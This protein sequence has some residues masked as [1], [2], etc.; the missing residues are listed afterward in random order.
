[1]QTQSKIKVWDP[2]V[3]VFHWTLVGTFLITF[4]TEDDFMSLHVWAGYTVFFAVLIRLVWGLI[5]TQH[6]RFSDFVTSP[7]VAFQYLRDTLLLRAKR[8]I[9][10]NPAGG[11]MIV[12]M[13]ISLL[14]TTITGI[15]VYGAEEQAG[16]MAGWFASHSLW[17]DV[18]EESH[19]FLSFFTLFLVFVHVAGVVI[20]S[21]IHKENLVRAMI[22]GTKK[23]N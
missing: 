10:H 1:M 20:E 4:I 15:A 22:D 3:R 7:K 23:A 21:L 18:L 11:L 13:I 6:A 17:E 2:L 19:E 16:P 8:Y 12:A 9:G 14:L 5:G